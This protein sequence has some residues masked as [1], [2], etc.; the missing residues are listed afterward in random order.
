MITAVFSSSG[1]QW[2]A[3]AVHGH[4]GFAESGHDIVCAAVTSSV[5]LAVN[6]MTDVLHAPAK[7]R[8]GKDSVVLWLD[9]PGEETGRL[10]EGLYRHLCLLKEQAPGCV[11]VV[12]LRAASKN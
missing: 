6:T 5:E 8:V 3:F 4:A 9:R 10:V 7:V 2:R 1:G 11:R 12:R